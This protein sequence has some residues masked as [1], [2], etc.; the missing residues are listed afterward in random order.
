LRSRFSAV[1]VLWV[2]V[3]IPVQMAC[4]QEVGAYFG[5]GSAHDSSNGQ[6][7]NTFSDG[8]L[9]NTPSMGGLFASLGANVFFGKHVGVGAEL[10]WK[11]SEGNYVGL[12]YRPSIASF[13]AIFRPTK[14]CAPQKIGPT[15]SGPNS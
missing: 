15:L 1:V 13:D 7:I 5:L 3:A 10:S 2:G 14:G 8:N 9:N 6:Q 12:L 4:G 11:P